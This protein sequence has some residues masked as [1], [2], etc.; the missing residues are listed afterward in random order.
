M[1]FPNPDCERFCAGLLPVYPEV[2]KPSR[3]VEGGVP[4]SDFTHAGLPG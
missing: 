1:S 3:P 2:M 4:W